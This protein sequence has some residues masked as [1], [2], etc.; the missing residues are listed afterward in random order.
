MKFVYLLLLV[1]QLVLAQTNGSFEQP[2]TSSFIYR[3]TD[4]TGAWTFANNSG[5][6]HNGSPFGASN[7]PDGVQTA[8]IQ[9]GTTPPGTISQTL[10]MQ[11]GS[12]TI[13]FSVA[14]RVQQIQPIK[15]ML[16]GLQVGGTITPASQSFAQVSIPITVTAGQHTIAIAGTVSSGDVTTFVDSVVVS[17]RSSQQLSCTLSAQSL[18]PSTGA[19]DTLTDTCTGSQGTVTYSWVNCSSTTNQCQATSDVGGSVTY[20]VTATDGVTTDTDSITLNWQSSSGSG[21]DLTP[22]QGN[23]VL[24]GGIAIGSSNTADSGIVMGLGNYG[25]HAAIVA[26]RYS[27]AGHPGSPANDAIAFGAGAEVYGDNG[28]AFGWNNISS[29]DRGFITGNRGND[30]RIEL[31]HTF[32]Y[33]GLTYLGDDAHAIVGEAQRIEIGLRGIT[34]DAT[35]KVLTSAQDLIHRY[36]TGLLM[37]G[38]SGSYVTGRCIARKPATGQV[39]AWSFEAL[40]ISGP[41]ISGQTPSSVSVQSV[42]TPSPF[43]APPA[44]NLTI[45]ADQNFGQVEV[46][47]T[48][49]A[50]ET[51]RWVCQ[52][53]S[54]ETQDQ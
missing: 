29:G 10:T 17:S 44:W 54:V 7:A 14:R 52:V 19:T 32:G 30:R 20:S 9:S 38:N 39:K 27:N 8:F 37:G 35:P 31:N 1:P 50:G 6:Q 3:P 11:A 49:G 24:N 2:V 23:T 5:V 18:T 13:S 33:G 48:G 45:Q 28:V 25:N 34:T 22:G 15:V 4:P 41:I 12:Y 53:I 21:W 36:D 42:V 47:A 26:G 40:A 46:V 51:I 16:D 43:A